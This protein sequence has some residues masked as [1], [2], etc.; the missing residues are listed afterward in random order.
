MKYI[1][2]LRN[3][4]TNRVQFQT[5]GDLPSRAVP[6]IVDGHEVEWSVVYLSLE[7]RQIEQVEQELR[8]ECRGYLDGEGYNISESDLLAFRLTYFERGVRSVLS[9]RQLVPTVKPKRTKRRRR[10]MQ[11][12]TWLKE[13]DPRL[14]LPVRTV[15][16][17]VGVSPSTV[18]NAVTY[19]RA[20]QARRGG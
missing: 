6:M 12:V 4:A 1:L 10:M 20:E 17:E 7:D 2:A 9:S 18:Q 3:K 13:H 19:L 11:A 15:A 16:K 14:D 5:C 8:D